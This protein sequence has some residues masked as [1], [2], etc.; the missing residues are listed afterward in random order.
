MGA[1]PEGVHERLI[2]EAA[3]IRLGDSSREWV[4]RRCDDLD[5]TE[6]GEQIHQPRYMRIL[7]R[8]PL[9]SNVH[10]D[11]RRSWPG[12]LLFVKALHLLP[13]DRGDRGPC[14][15]AVSYRKP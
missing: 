1:C 7:F 8:A 11:Q 15:V 4:S 13:R 5:A 12:R 9:R 14:A 6:A 10:C 2:D 3:N